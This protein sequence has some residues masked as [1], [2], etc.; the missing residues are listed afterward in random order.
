MA[1]TATETGLT[2]GARVTGADRQAL[3]ARLAERYLA[4]ESIR[5]L[6]QETG[7]SFGFVHGVIKESGVALRSRGGATRR[8]APSTALATASATSSAPAE[9][10]APK[11]K[12][13]KSKKIT[14]KKDEGKKDEGKKSLAKK[15]AAKKEKAAGGKKKARS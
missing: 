13:A 14:R 3:G 1:K 5:S 11:T 12:V 7:R 10:T 6:A 8:S 2:K 15:D 4:G 9:G